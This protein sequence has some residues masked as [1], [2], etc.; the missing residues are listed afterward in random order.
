MGAEVKMAGRAYGIPSR[1]VREG[2]GSLVF[3]AP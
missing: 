3:V 1:K 2:I